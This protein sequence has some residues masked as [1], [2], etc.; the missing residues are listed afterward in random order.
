[1]IDEPRFSLQVDHEITLGLLSGE[2]ADRLFHLIDQDRER[3]R[4]W[5]PWVDY[6]RAPADSLTYIR[7]A[8]QQFAE[9]ESLQLGIFYQDQLAGTI[10]CHTIDWP[11][12]S[13]EI[14]Y[15]LSSSCEGRGVMTRA[16]RRLVSYVF[17]SLTLNRVEI[18]CATA[19]RK[20]RA[21]PERLGFVQEG[22]RREG[23]WLNDHFVDLVLYG[24]LAREWS[25]KNGSV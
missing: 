19:N 20:S 22:I 4:E 21:I 6:E 11:D 8:Q 7:R 2:H 13:V 17:A 15:W 24:M 9:N 10:G 16:C 14:G 25:T 3:L 18:Q 5:L 1:M 12:R 23:E